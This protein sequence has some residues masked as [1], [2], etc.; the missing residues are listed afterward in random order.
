MARGQG[1]EG[2]MP[3][4]TAGETLRLATLA[5]GRQSALQGNQ[6]GAAFKNNSGYCFLVAAF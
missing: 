5:Q 4:W 3:A 1:N 2:K 6:R